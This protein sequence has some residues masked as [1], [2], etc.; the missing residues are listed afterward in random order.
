M[1]LKKSNNEKQTETIM[2]ESSKTQMRT[3]LEQLEDKTTTIE[4]LENQMDALTKK[5]RSF[6]EKILATDKREMVVGEAY[7]WNNFTTEILLDKANDSFVKRESDRKEMLQRLADI[8]A[9]AQFEAEKTQKELESVK[10]RIKENSGFAF[11]V[12]SDADAESN[13]NKD[14]AVIQKFIETLQKKSPTTL[15]VPIANS[16]LKIEERKKEKERIRQQKNADIDRLMLTLNKEDWEII[17]YIGRTGESV[18]TSIVKGVTNNS[19]LMEKEIYLYLKNLENKLII[20]SVETS[21]VN[22]RY[23]LHK[24]SVNVGCEVYRKRFGK[25]PVLSEWEKIANEHDNVVHGY[26]IKG[27]YEILSADNSPFTDVSMFNRKNH[28]ITTPQGKEFVPDIFAV[29]KKNKH[30]CYIEYERGEG[31]ANDFIYK[32]EKIASTTNY[33]YFVAPTKRDI[34]TKII[35]KFETWIKSREDKT[36]F[37]SLVILISTPRYIKEALTRGSGKLWNYSFD[38]QSLSFREH[39][40]PKPK[41]D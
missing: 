35:P 41:E 1:L 21:N 24:L 5:T 36:I 20:D 31:T 13:L 27:L 26:G 9:D 7:S 18:K 37:N 30:E 29:T 17:E 33:L 15:S 11:V 8:A 28:T 19:N 16:R 12:E 32:C 4:S 2:R 40:Q 22:T 25:S 14:K 38:S 10:E 34:E 6:C 3:L 39:S 23:I